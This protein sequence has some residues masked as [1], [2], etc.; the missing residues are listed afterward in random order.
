MTN[1]EWLMNKLAN[2][3]DE[4]FAHTFLENNPTCSDDYGWVDRYT[5]P[6]NRRYE[7]YQREGFFGEMQD[8]TEEIFYEDYDKAVKDFVVWL[9][10]EHKE[11]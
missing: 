3:S 6:F 11:G 8:H 7:T 9:N 2:M 10:E 1:R 5:N 4:I